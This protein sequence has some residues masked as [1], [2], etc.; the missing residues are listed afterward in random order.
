[1]RNPEVVTEQCL[2]QY[3]LSLAVS[4]GLSKTG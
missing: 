4:E 1:V 2:L 3:Y